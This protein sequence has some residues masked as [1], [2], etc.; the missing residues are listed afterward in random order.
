MINNITRFECRC[1]GRDM[2]CANCEGEGITDWI[3]NVV[4]KQGYSY[5]ALEKEVH[6]IV[7]SATFKIKDDHTQQMIKCQLEEYVKSLHS[8]NMISDYQISVERILISNHIEFTIQIK[9]FRSAE[10]V[11]VNM[12]VA[13]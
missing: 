1:K 11:T 9:P 5:R 3:G 7:S 2:F 10:I 4:P 6:N 12:R 8:Q 13:G